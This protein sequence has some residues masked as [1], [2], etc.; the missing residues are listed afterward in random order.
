[1][2]PSFA[3]MDQL[4][5]FDS[6]LKEIDKNLYVFEQEKVKTDERFEAIKSRFAELTKETSTLFAALSLPKSIKLKFNL[7]FQDFHL[8]F[9]LHNF[10]VI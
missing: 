4:N 3:F 2:Q 6:R 9:P 7:S 10:C 8:P 1:M 5:S